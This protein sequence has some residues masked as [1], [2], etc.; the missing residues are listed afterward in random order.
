MITLKPER[1]R[2]NQTRKHDM[3][4]TAQE[5]E[6]A[7]RRAVEISLF[8]WRRADDSD[9]VDGND[10]QG[11]WGDSYPSQVNDRIGSRL[12]LLRRK[13]ITVQTIQDAKRYCEEALNWLIDDGH[14]IT[15]DVTI[16]RSFTTKLAGL[17]VLGRPNN[18]PLSFNFD[19]LLQV[20]NNAV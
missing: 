16:T 8:T 11:W 1:Q 9:Q 10:K 5:Q 12:W 17:I 20:E 7:L 3:P 18:D 13:T 6:T 2:A 14:V 4:M 19:D 15:V